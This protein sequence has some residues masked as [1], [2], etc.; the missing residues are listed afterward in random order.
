ML[1][2]KKIISL[3][4]LFC[5]K[6]I[7]NG[8]FIASDKAAAA[9]TERWQDGQSQN[10]QLRDFDRRLGDPYTSASSRFPS[11]RNVGGWESEDGVRIAEAVASVFALRS[12]S[13]SELPF[14]ARRLLT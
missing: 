10:L 2:Y 14:G 5:I 11:L 7:Q 3:L 13:S 12:R 1:L 6:A 8:E 4:D 9:A